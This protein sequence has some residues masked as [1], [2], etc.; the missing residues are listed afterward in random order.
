MG[1]PLTESERH[2]NET[3][4]TVTLTKSFYMGEYEVTQAQYEAVMGT[5]TKPS[6]FNG[7]NLPVKQVRWY[8]AIVFC[9]KL[10]IK[11]NLTPAYSIN[12]KTNPAEW[13]I[14]NLLHEFN[15]PVWDAV[16]CNWTANGYR[17]PTEAEWEYACRAGTTTPFSTGNNITTDKANYDGNYPYNGN[18]RGEYRGTTTEVGTFDANPWGL[19][20]MH[21]NMYEWCWDWYGRYQGD[22]TDPRGA[23][24]G[25]IRVIRG[26]HWD[27]GARDLR[28]AS[29]GGP[30]EYDWDYGFGFRIVR[31]VV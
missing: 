3:Q 22:E 17:L 5:G 12:G 10:S 6:Y 25:T 14:L 1:S 9:N 31:P 4:H 23:S 21:G 11:E 15:D 24:S 19:Y 27:Y 30:D 18:P 28:S 8:D 29:R 2:S 26:G 7:D 16:V 20:D 13:P